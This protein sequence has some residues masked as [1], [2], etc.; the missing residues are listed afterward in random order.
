MADQIY[1]PERLQELNKLRAHRYQD[2]AESTAGA[3]AEA[4]TEEDGLS[5]PSE[6]SDQ[7]AASEEQGEEDESIE[8][9]IAR[10]LAELKQ[11]HEQKHKGSGAKRRDRLAPK[12][13]SKPKGPK[14]RFVSVQT[15]T[16]CRKRAAGEKWMSKGGGLIPGRSRQYAFSPRHG[17]MTQSRS[18]KL[19]LHKHKRLGCHRPGERIKYEI[20]IP[21]LT[22]AFPRPYPC[23]FATKIHATLVANCCLMSRAQYRTS[24]G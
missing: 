2:P 10:E 19:S 20:V 9:T 4:Q 23:S 14:P 11:D 16:E 5:G 15:N 8:A 13:Q 17:R 12:D 22:D 7:E 1:P 24:R 18:L 6:G 3:T 21:S